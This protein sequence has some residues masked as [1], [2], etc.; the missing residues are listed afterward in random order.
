MSSLLNVPEEALI[1]AEEPLYTSVAV[2]VGGLSQWHV[3]SGPR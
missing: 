3:N 2:V 1:N